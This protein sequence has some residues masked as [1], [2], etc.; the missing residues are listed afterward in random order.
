MKKTGS[1][2]I[3]TVLRNMALVI[4][5]FNALPRWFAFVRIALGVPLSA[6]MIWIGFFSAASGGFVAGIGVVG[7]AVMIGIAMMIG[8]GVLTANF[9]RK[10]ERIRRIASDSVVRH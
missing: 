2:K 6:A 1:Q 7:V 5:S 4:E 9:W 10:L 8:G 3:R